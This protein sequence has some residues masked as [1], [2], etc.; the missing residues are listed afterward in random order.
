MKIVKEVN[1]V[2]EVKRGDVSPVAMFY[3]KV[4]NKKNSGK[5]DHVFSQVRGEF[6][7]NPFKRISVIIDAYVVKKNLDISFQLSKVSCFKSFYL[8]IFEY[9]TIHHFQ[10]ALNNVADLLSVVPQY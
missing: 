3:N 4:R 2:E 1:I 6:E 9:R 7:E 10:L 5:A 8:N